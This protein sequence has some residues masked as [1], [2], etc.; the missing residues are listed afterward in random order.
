MQEESQ[1]HSTNSKIQLKADIGQAKQENV[2]PDKKK[3]SFFFFAH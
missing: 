3:K 2:T 1:L